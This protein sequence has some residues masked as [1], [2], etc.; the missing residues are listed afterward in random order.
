MIPFAFVRPAVNREIHIVVVKVCRGPGR[1]TVAIL[2]GCRKSR[3]SVVWIVCL[4]IFRLVAAVTGVGRVVVIAVMTGGAVVG[5]ERMRA[6]Q[7]IIIVVNIECSRRPA[8]CGGVATRAIRR[9][10]Q[11]HV[12]RV[13]ALVVIVRVTARAGVGRIVV[14]AVD[15][16][17]IT[18]AGNGDVRARERIKIV[19][20][21][22]RGHPR[23]FRVTTGAVCRELGR[24]V[25]GVGGLVIIVDVATCAGVGRVVVVAVV[26]GG[27][28]I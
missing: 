5:N 18:V 14:V 4:I 2:A 7:R 23:R 22:R 26:A 6:V 28:I 10:V 27:T 11:R 3:R 15:V 17:G 13:G 21:E 16:T 20:V 12:V 19:V 9:K 25:V 1:F 24:F 8:G